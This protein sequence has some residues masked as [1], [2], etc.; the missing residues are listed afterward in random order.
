M[1]LLLGIP[2]LMSPLLEIVPASGQL[3]KTSKVNTS[4]SSFLVFPFLMWEAVTWPGSLTVLQRA[5]KE[6]KHYFY[7]IHTC[8]V[9]KKLSGK[10]C[11]E[12]MVGEKS[13]MLYSRR[14]CEGN[15]I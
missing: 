13:F 3:T 10:K 14:V 4:F 15:A 2:S 6:D 1:M 7:F 11:Y 5:C 9:N 12:R 8:Y